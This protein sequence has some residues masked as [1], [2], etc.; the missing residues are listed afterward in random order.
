M[1]TYNWI[2]NAWAESMTFA[3][4]D[5]KGAPYHLYVGYNVIQNA[6]Y[7]WGPTRG[8]I[9]GDWVQIQPFGT[10]NSVV[11]NFNTWIQD[12]D[13]SLA[14][15][16]GITYAPLGSGY[17][18]TCEYNYNTIIVDPAAIIAPAWVGYT[19]GWQVTNTIN[20]NYQNRATG[21]TF[22]NISQ[23]GPHGGTVSQTGNINMLTGGTI[24]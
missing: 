17:V 23:R 10:L 11:F 22:N 2:K 7:G 13:S 1:V 21:L 20:Y 6:G 3:F 18:E 16:Q 4:V 5:S 12:A 19:L 14:R 9:H 15:A 24:R 8:A